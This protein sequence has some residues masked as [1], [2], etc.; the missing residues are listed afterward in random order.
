MSGFPWPPGE[1]FGEGREAGGQTLHPGQRWERDFLIL[2]TELS[3]CQGKLQE[4]HRLLQSL[5]SLHRIPSAPVIP[6]HQVRSRGGGRLPSRGLPPA[7]HVHPITS[8]DRSL[9]PLMSLLFS[10][11]PHI[12]LV[13]SSPMSILPQGHLSAPLERP[14]PPVP[15]YLPGCWSSS[16]GMSV[17]SAPSP[18]TTCPSPG[19]DGC[20]PFSPP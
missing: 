13:A 4:L 15:T 1:V 16:S 9:V 3:E 5:E 19:F 10:G 6:T 20:C 8:L 2:P 18:M 14:L 17:V 11:E 7:C 12:C